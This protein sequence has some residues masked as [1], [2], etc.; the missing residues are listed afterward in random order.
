MYQ[1]MYDECCHDFPTAFVTTYTSFE[2]YFDCIVASE[3]GGL[4]NK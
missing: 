1:K 2:E 4:V 3:L